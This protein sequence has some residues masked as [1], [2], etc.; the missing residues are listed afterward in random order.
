MY[1]TKIVV[2]RHQKL[3]PQD[4]QSSRRMEFH[5]LYHT[6]ILLLVYIFPDF[7]LDIFG[8]MECPYIVHIS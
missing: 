3:N 8:V 1:T 4:N 2:D 6:I 7:I 5:H